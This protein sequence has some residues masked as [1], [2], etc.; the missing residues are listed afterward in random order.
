MG[1]VANKA[2]AH[3]GHG[4][5]GRAS[6]G[7]SFSARHNSLNLLRLVLALLV[8]L[9]H[10]RELGGYSS[11]YILGNNKTTLGTLAVYGFF[12]IS[13][14]LIAASA[15]RNGIWRYLWQRFLR[16]FPAFWVCLFV[17]AGFFGIIGWYHAH[18]HCGISCYLH[19]PLGP[20]DYVLRNSWLRLNQHAIAG[21][22]KGVPLPGTWDGSLWTLFY[23]FLCYLV[24]GVLAMTTLLRHRWVVAAL[25]AAVWVAEIVITSVPNLNAQFNLFRNWDA[26]VMLALLPVFLAGSLIYLYRDKI[27]DSGAIALAC[28]A[29][30]LISLA[31]PLGNKFPGLTLTSTNLFA[32]ALGY[33]MLWLGI[34][35]P[36]QRVGARNDYS[37]GTYIYAYPVAQL[38]ALWG[39]YR[40]G[41]P[42]FTAL[43]ILLTAPFAVA[44][45]WLIEKRALRL[46]HVTLRS[47]TNPLTSERQESVP[48]LGE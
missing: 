21:T 29:L 1:G 34:H 7:Q 43:T 35:L 41:Y 47:L 20:V 5:V 4:L 38:L 16:I 9:S 11:E 46:K 36:F 3:G 26:S 12:G 22:P 33:L 27:P 14:Y 15:S 17:T 45:W 23:E 10:D 39:V 40:W 8:V 31:V 42:A 37:Y 24:L 6:V 19:A 13:G 25:T 48:A 28:V 32:P 18:S 2:T 44:S 30:V